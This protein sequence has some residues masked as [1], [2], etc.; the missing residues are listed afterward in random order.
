M[1][2]EAVQ[3][4]SGIDRRPFCIVLQLVKRRSLDKVKAMMAPQETTEQALLRV[5]CEVFPLLTSTI[6]QHRSAFCWDNLVKASIASFLLC[7]YSG[8]A[9]WPCDI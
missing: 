9:G 2:V 6:L 4:L 7:T 1:T 3:T 8:P 5:C